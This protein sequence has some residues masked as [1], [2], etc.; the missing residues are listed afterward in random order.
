MLV[1][2]S[3]VLSDRARPLRL[4]RLC[5]TGYYV[6]ENPLYHTGEVAKIAYTMADADVAQRNAINLV[7]AEDKQRVPPVHLMCYFNV[8]QDVHKYL[9]SS[10]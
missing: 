6:R 5:I 10:P 7:V 8:M 2:Y 9:K 1:L 4:F 3:I